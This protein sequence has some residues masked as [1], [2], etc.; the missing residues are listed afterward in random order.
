M[1]VSIPGPEVGSDSLKVKFLIISVGRKP[2]FLAKFPGPG[3]TFPQFPLATNHAVE[4]A[5]V[6]SPRWS[7]ARTLTP[8]Q[9]KPRRGNCNRGN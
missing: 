7:P 3:G 4:T 1:P 8:R 2:G 5:V 9:L 6:P